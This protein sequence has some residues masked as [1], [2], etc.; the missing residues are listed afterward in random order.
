MSKKC[1]NSSK[2]THS[3]SNMRNITNQCRIPPK[4]EHKSHN[5]SIIPY[6]ETTA[7][8]TELKKVE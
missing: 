7:F 5:C 1:K 4:T 2:S 3:K 6:N 8:V